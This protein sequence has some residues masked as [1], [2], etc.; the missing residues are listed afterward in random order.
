M[1]KATRRETNSPRGL[2]LETATAQPKVAPKLER[3]R[4]RG[5][6]TSLGREPILVIDRAKRGGSGALHPQSAIAGLKSRPRLVAVGSVVAEAALRAGSRATETREPRQVRKEAAVSG[7]FRV[8]RG[9]LVGAGCAATP[10]AALSTAGARSHFCARSSPT[11]FLP[12]RRSAS[13]FPI[14]GAS[15]RNRR[16]P[17]RIP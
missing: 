11:S 15:S 9:C 13:A 4:D 16:T 14:C 5:R 3:S 8:P 2:R 10:G 7:P 17:R 6:L 1:R 12:H